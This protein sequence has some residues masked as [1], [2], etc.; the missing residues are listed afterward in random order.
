MT[1][2]SLITATLFSVAIGCGDSDDKAMTPDGSTPGA[3]PHTFKVHVENIAPWVAL[4]SGTIDTKLDN[5]AGPAGPGGAWETTFTA[6]K[7][8]RLSFAT[9]FGQ[10]NDWFFGPGP[11][12]IALFDDQGNMVTGDVTSQVKLWDAGTEVDQEPNVGPDTG[13]KQATPTQGAADPIAMVRELG[14]SITLTDGSTFVRPATTAMIKVTLAKVADRTFTLRIENV[15]TATTLHTSQGNTGI[16]LSPPL[17]AV[18][19]A[20]A[21]L[22]MTGT[23]DRAQGL[24]NIAESG[25]NAPLRSS[26]TALTG[27]PTPISPGVWAVHRDPEPLYGLGL[28]DRGQGLEHLAED[29]NNTP[30]GSSMT[31]LAATGTVASAGVFDIPDNAQAK[32]P[33][34][35]GSGFTLEV[36][37]SP[38]DHLSFA[39]MFGMSNDWIFATQPEGIAL[40]ASDGSPLTGDVTDQIKIYDVGTEV[41]QEPA[42]GPD[43]APQQAAPNTGANDADNLVREVAPARYGM[44][45]SAHLRITLEP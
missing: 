28:A 36:T 19:V 5:T 16:G 35:P 25:N 4:K 6:G 17:Y 7:G 43:T 1:K 24:E 41:D 9:M 21:P 14:T 40:F 39:T 27:W 20:S 32:G 37:A 15:S 11:D 26:V 3:T 44:P 29:G 10:S 8:Q 31:Q 33:A 22:F 42:I 2:L 45:A 23:A 12:G 38:G 18:H 34:A 30:I 13:P